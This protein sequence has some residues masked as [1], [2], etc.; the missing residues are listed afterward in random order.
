MK[1]VLCLLLALLLLLAGCGTAEPGGRIEAPE[2]TEGKT[3]TIIPAE[4][5]TT[6][7][8]VEETEAV[9]EQGDKEV[10][11]GRMEG[12]TY[13]NEYI[14]MACTLDSNWSYYTAEEL[15]VLPENTKEMFSDSAIAETLEQY[16]Q[17]TD[18]MAENVNDFT[19]IGVQY[20]QL[21]MAERVLYAMMSEEEL[22]DTVLDTQR[23]TLIQTMESAGYQI[24]K[25]EK[26]TVTF[27]GETRTALYIES[28]LQGLNVYQVQLM[29][30]NL[31]KYAVNITFTSILEDKTDDLLALFYKV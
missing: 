3:S 5:E 23:E 26:K 2:A 25:L 16:T 21:P 4:Q 12:G 8:P 14:G 27:L 24:N 6:E 30:Y 7:A 31:G 17:I 18:M 13:I 15:Q 9:Q 29:D 22:I 11:L 1:K 10:S 20:T 19:N 28:Q